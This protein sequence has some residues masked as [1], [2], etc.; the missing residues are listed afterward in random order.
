LSGALSLVLAVQITLFLLLFHRPVYAMASLVVGQFTTASYMVPLSGATLISVRF[1]WT[2]LAFLLL[3]PILR[4]IGRIEL[5]TQAKRIIIPAI[6]FFCLA[7]IA[8]AVNTNM[9]VTT[10]YLRIF[11]TELV[12]L[13]LMPAAIKNE[14]DVKILSLV[15]LITCLVS[16][17]VA[18]MQHYSFRG[19]PVFTIFPGIYVQGRT[20]GLTEGAVNLAFNLP[21]VILPATAIYFLRGL[22]KRARRIIV[23]LLL[24]MVAALYF[25]YTRSGMYALAPGLLLMALLMKGKP[26]KEIILVALVLAAGFLYYID[27]QGNRYSKGFKEESSAA[28]RLVLWKVGAEIALDNPILGIGEGKFQETS[29]AYSGTVTSGST[30]VQQ[31]ATG[32]LGLVPVHNDFLR[33]WEAFGTPALIAYLWLFAGIFLNLL[34]A[35]RRS[36]TR[37]LKGLSLGCLG[38]M[39]GYI[40]NA[41]TH[42]VM[43]SAFFLWIFGGLSIAIVKLA[44]SQPLKAK[45]LG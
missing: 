31:R 40:V 1:I 23:V 5:G 44:L 9:T 21:M 10:Q 7:T 22:E 42:N 18:V 28:G 32:D 17:I 24:I 11:A 37:F 29:L 39:A 15:A 35:Y 30:E 16:A 4:R 25:T 34:D 43:D 38:A 20:T 36:Q 45:E 33:V 2:I 3:I 12:I 14:K 41:A 27:M 8:N 6:I 13:V 19:L 26:K